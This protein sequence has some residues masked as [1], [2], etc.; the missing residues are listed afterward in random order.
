MSRWTSHGYCLRG[1]G[2]FGPFDAPL[3]DVA[4]RNLNDHNERKGNEVDLGFR[5]V[6]P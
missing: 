3:G 5:Q 6:I 2:S 4:V 1:G